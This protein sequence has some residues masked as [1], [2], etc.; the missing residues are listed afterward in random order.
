VWSSGG[1][2]DTTGLKSYA[3]GYPE[4]QDLL[5]SELAEI[6]DGGEFLTDDRDG[7]PVLTGRSLLI[8]WDEVTYA[9]FIPG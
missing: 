8:R 3:A 6:D 5:I 9:E 7:T 1:E 2:S 4:S